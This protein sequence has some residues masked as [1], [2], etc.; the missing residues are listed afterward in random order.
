M[1]YIRASVPLCLIP[2]FDVRIEIYIVIFV[3]S[4]RGIHSIFVLVK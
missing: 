3:S 1:Y 2:A 4:S